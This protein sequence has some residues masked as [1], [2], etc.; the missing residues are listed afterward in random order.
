M[1]GAL[2]FL[3]FLSS[4]CLIFVSF[5]IL[6][7]CSPTEEPD[8]FPFDKHPEPILEAGFWHDPSHLPGEP[9]IV[10]KK[11]EQ[12]AY[13]YKGDALVGMTPVSTG[14]PGR[15]TPTGHYTVAEKVFV[16]YSGTFGSVK[17]NKTHE[18]VI[19]EFNTKKDKLP[20]GTYYEPARMAYCLRF[21][22]GYCM[23]Q[24]YVTGE[25]ISN[26][27]IRVPQDM[28]FLFYQHAKT[29]MTFIVQ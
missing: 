6:S 5:G 25:P 8:W 18:T 28:A 17:D 10:I 12:R 1:Q 14:R 24:G 9:K 23:H 27:C 15:G 13:F 20:A 11:A 7:S 29:G 26:G 19:P 16:R 2:R 4:L 3:S 21:F 22:N